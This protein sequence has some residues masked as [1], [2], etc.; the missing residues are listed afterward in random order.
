M[1]EGS[2][3]SR[4]LTPSGSTRHLVKAAAKL[5]VK[6]VCSVSAAEA[7]KMRSGRPAVQVRQ[8]TTLFTKQRLP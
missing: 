8:W 1:S 6:L 3:G 7:E 5:L 2:M 4:R